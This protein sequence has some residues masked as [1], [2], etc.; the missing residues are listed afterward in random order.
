MPLPVQ[1]A[2]DGQGVGAAVPLP[3]AWL[4]RYGSPRLSLPDPEQT[5]PGHR[6]PGMA[7]PWG[8]P[9][10]ASVVREVIRQ[11]PDGWKWLT[12]SVPIWAEVVPFSGSGNQGDMLHGIS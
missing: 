2:H 12:D 10:E 8:G 4:H 5:R 3:P 1:G 7:R 6:S 9:W 11:M